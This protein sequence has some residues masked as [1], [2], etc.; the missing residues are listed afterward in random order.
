MRIIKE[1][2]NN[3]HKR[4]TGV[5]LDEVYAGLYGSAGLIAPDWGCVGTK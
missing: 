4:N 1:F 5:D 3:E 2:N